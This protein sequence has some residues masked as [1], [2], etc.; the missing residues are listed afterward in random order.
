MKLN[1]KTIACLLFS[2]N[3]GVI[4]T[5]QDA[6]DPLPMCDAKPNSAMQC[7]EWSAGLSGKPVGWEFSGCLNG[8]VYANNHSPASR[9]NGIY[10]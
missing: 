5:A 2:A 10:N 4:G 7:D 9:F 6:S 1:W 3:T 8:G